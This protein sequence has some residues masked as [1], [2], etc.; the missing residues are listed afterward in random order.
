M[1]AEEGRMSLTRARGWKV[2]TLLALMALIPGSVLAQSPSVPA[3][4][5]GATGA[6]TGAQIAFF[7][8]LAN[9][10]VAATIE[11]INSVAGPA[12]AQVTQFDTGF[13]ATLEF[14]QVQDAVAQ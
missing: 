6:G 9:S 8:P 3:G 2:S 12:G 13:D 1:E 10:Y 4:S 14:S 5:P 7:A 11:G